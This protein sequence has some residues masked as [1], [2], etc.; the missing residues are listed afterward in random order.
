ME[1]ASVSITVLINA[2]YAR[3]YNALQQ[4][5]A[6]AFGHE[7]L[8]FSL[9][10]ATFI[11]LAVYQLYLSQ[12]LQIRWRQWM[13]GEFLSVWLK[14]ALPYRMQVGGEAPDNPDQRI[15]EDIRLF[16][17]GTLI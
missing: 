15:A 13:T 10:A 7:L 2:W 12:W 1:L 3:F 17:S 9:L 4:R 8:V 11:A 5:N 16:V 6:S 14:D